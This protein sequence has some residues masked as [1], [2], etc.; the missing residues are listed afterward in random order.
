MNKFKYIIFIIFG[1]LL[2]LLLNI[3]NTFSIGNQYKLD[4]TNTG[5][6]NSNE[7]LKTMFNTIRLE[8]DICMQNKFEQC[9]MTMHQSGGSC[10][11]NTLV[12]FY[13]TALGVGFSQEDR[14]Y[15]NSQGSY[16]KNLHNIE[17]TYDYLTNRE[18]MKPLL[19]HN[20]INS[21]VSLNVVN[22]NIT[23]LKLDHLYP[24]Y[25][26]FRTYQPPVFFREDGTTPYDFGHNMLMYKTNYAGLSSFLE[27]LYSEG[28]DIYSSN[29]LYGDLLRNKNNI[30]P[31]IYQNNGIGILNNG[32]V[33]IMI[34][35]CNKL[36][37]AVTEYS[38]PSTLDPNLFDA[39]G[40]IPE[41]N[42]Q[43]YNDLW[44][45]KLVSSFAKTRSS[46][47]KM[48][49]IHRDEN[50][51]INFRALTQN[52]LELYLF[53]TSFLFHTYLHEDKHYNVGEDPVIKNR[54]DFLGFPN[55]LC[56][57]PDQVPPVPPCRS[58]DY[59]CHENFPVN[60][61]Q[62]S[63]CKTLGQLNSSCRDVEPRCND[64]SFVDLY[65][66]E[67]DN[68]CKQSGE[69]N[70]RCR[71]SEQRC[72]SNLQCIDNFCRNDLLL[73]NDDAILDSRRSPLFNGFYVYNT[74]WTPGEII[75]YR[76]I[77]DFINPIYLGIYTK[78]AISSWGS[79]RERHFFIQYDGNNLVLLYGNFNGIFFRQVGR[80]T[81]KSERFWHLGKPNE[82]DNPDF[83]TIYFNDDKY[84]SLSATSQFYTTDTLSRILDYLD[85]VLNNPIGAVGDRSCA[86]RVRY[87]M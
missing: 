7:V 5:P 82:H 44:R 27:Y 35:F 18:T 42:V 41:T 57:N 84:T 78:T 79:D 31:L 10:Q 39:E 56:R 43:R 83:I 87:Y 49:F 19:H 25:I 2:F 68:I 32:I 45:V 51:D 58:H 17:T 34:D 4:R 20:D 71:D 64:G 77:R 75:A 13:Q 85:L 33:C 73:Y 48:K 36:F 54:Q 80:K 81:I 23:E 53:L 72:R 15:I 38:N 60:N 69:L 61:A 8:H 55:T 50:I 76:N 22:S 9:Y 86:V 21:N 1:I 14:D 59:Y 63:V 65:C 70:N 67:I 16:L 6:T 3:T 26:G 12:G 29:N 30:D 40:N 47:Y 11:I 28:N 37:Y 24:I 46:S 62:Y 74:N 52:N 66:D